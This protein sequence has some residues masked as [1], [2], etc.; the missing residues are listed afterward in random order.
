M[1]VLRTYID[2]SGVKRRKS[3]GKYNFCSHFIGIWFIVH[4]S[5]KG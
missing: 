5:R 2:K 3:P 1:V 4:V